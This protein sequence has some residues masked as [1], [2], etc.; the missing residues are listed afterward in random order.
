M[1]CWFYLIN[2]SRIHSV[3]SIATNITNVQV[4]LALLHRPASLPTSS[5]DPVQSYLHNAARVIISPH[6]SEQF[7]L[8]L[9]MHTE[10][11]I[12]EVV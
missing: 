4:N 8:S 5:L 10:T 11:F 9:Q 7:A 6:K 2:V 3:I 12:D 1:S